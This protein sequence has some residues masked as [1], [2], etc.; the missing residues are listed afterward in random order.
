MISVCIATYNG[1]KYIK[2]QI[3][4]ILSQLGE[5]DEVIVS[6]DGSADRTLD[7][8]RQF[9]DTRIKIAINTGRHGYTH[10]FE[11]ALKQAAGDYIF[12]SD[13]D[14]VWLQGKV[15]TMLPLLEA[16]D[17]L[18]VTDAYI[19][20]EKLEIRRRLSEYRR[21]HP[22]YWRN[23]YTAVYMGCTNA[24]TRR[25][26]DYCLPFPQTSLIQH[27]NWIG[28]LCELKFKVAYLDE[29][30]VLYRR[31][32]GNTSGTGSQSTRSVF[33]MLR[34]RMALLIGTLIHF[35]LKHKT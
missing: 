24:F 19:T 9:G 12:L 29:P 7:V 28:L 15:K 5:G 16:D 11:N 26:K 30:L 3:A 4:S 6:D 14:D 2:E 23:L 13:Q 34:Y 20:D 18:V 10:N 27:D 17:C 31:H 35:I 25:V 1:E 8:V 32:S 21:Y 33:F 22:G